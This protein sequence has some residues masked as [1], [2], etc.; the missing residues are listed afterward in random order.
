MSD[1][2]Y[3]ITSKWGHWFQDR[4]GSRV[5]VSYESFRDFIVTWGTRDAELE[6]SRRSG[7]LKKKLLVP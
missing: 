6:F 4:A 5:D 2:L 1:W 7:A 3:P